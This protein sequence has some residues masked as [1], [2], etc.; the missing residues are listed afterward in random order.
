LLSVP[1]L[2][3]VPAFREGQ[4]RTSRD[5]R[6]LHGVDGAP[7]AVVHEAPAL[8]TRMTVRTMGNAPA[9]AQ[10]E[11]LAV[12]AEAGRLFAGA[13][14]GELTP[15]GYCRAQ[16]LASGVPIG[17]ARG[18]LSRV[19]DDCG[20]LGEV[21]A[22]QAPV[23][24]GRTARWVRRGTVLGVVAPSNHPATHGAW[25]QAV[26]MG[27]R[28]AVRPGARDPFTPLRLATALTAA[29]LPAGW[30]SVLPGPHAAADALLDA[31]DLSL[32]YGGAD[33]VARL[34]GNDRVLVRGPGR[35][36]ILI[37]RPVDGAT[38][39]HLVA[40]IASDG[41]V[42]CTNTTAVF[43]SGDHRALAQALAERLA[44]LPAHPVTDDRAVLPVRPRREAEGLRTVLDRHAHGAFDL[45]PKFH[46]DGPLAAVGDDAVA[47][48]PAVICVDSADHPGL[49]VELPFPCVWVAPWR[50]SEG[51]GPLDGSL[52]L[53]LLTDDESLVAAALDAPGIRTVLHGPVPGWWK[54]PFLPHDG[55][56]AQFLLEA[57]GFAAASRRQPG[58]EPILR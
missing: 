9:V 16:A 20:R 45:V 29:G 43:C 32:V 22:R 52:A 11:R 3:S 48:R 26:A 41:G 14:L 58:T 57:R 42:R 1:A 21:V 24:A 40:E 15:D 53:T 33:T 38:L 35:T 44:Q 6:T 31:A 46:D 17:V 49:G 18:S 50:P 51:I 56:L 12:L 19:A 8:V 13:T 54:N 27:Y 10:D 25:L 34:R 39:D 37:D 55:Y 2:P 5:T 23:G 7:L 36:K 47:L 30:I 28:V 4:E